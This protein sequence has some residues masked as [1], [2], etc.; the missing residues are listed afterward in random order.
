MNTNENKCERGVRIGLGTASSNLNESVYTKG[1]HE[2]GWKIGSCGKSQDCLWSE[3][4]GDG[5]TNY[6][7][8]QVAQAH[9]L[10]PVTCIYYN[11]GKI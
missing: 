5:R 2:R 8:S 10:S 3:F 1:D 11:F 7:C 6:V 4:L 9:Y